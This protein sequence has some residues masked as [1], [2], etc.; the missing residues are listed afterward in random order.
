MTVKFEFGAR[1]APASPAR[2][3]Q[4]EQDCSGSNADSVRKYLTKDGRATSSRPAWLP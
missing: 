3:I 4:S 1:L 2:G